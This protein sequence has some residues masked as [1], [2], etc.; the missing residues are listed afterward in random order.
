MAGGVPQSTGGGAAARAG[1][2]GWA[3]LAALTPA[4]TDALRQVFDDVP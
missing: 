2:A 4:G 1:A 3:G